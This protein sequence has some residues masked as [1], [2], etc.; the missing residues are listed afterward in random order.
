MGDGGSASSKAVQGGEHSPALVLVL[1]PSSRLRRDED[2]DEDDLH[3]T[4]FDRFDPGLWN[5]VFVVV[6][7]WRP[8]CSQPTRPPSIHPSS[9]RLPFVPIP[10]L[11]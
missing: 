10:R 3:P 7:A 1:L 8:T 11:K 2:E 6:D 4:T 5:R 9:S